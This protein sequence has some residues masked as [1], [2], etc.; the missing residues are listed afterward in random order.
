MRSF[1]ICIYRQILFGWLNQ[2]ENVVEI[3]RT[4]DR[5]MHMNFGLGILKKRNN[6]EDLGLDGRIILKLIFMIH[7]GG[8]GLDSSG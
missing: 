1:I 2:E 6:L 7:V 8:C 3:C 5:E 4:Y